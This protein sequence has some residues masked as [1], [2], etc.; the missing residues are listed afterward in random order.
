MLGTNDSSLLRLC[1]DVQWPFYVIFLAGR[2]IQA[3]KRRTSFPRRAIRFACLLGVQHFSA[4]LQR[5]SRTLPYI[6]PLYKLAD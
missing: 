1:Y 4:A 5:W 2:T 6:W 3:Q